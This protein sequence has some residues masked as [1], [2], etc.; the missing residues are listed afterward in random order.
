MGFSW[1][2]FKPGDERRGSFG[3]C[4]PY[5]RFVAVAPGAIGKYQRCCLHQ[6]FCTSPVICFLA[7]LLSKCGRQH[8]GWILMSGHP[9]GFEMSA[10]E[11]QTSCCLF[12]FP[13]FFMCLCMRRPSQEEPREFL[14]SCSRFLV[15]RGA[16]SVAR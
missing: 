5:C 15:I 7:F 3:S 9:L 11:S 12:E 1:G 2:S 14:G 16:C 8:C 10:F 4:F 6:T 13:G